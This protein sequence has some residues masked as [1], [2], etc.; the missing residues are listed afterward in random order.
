MLSRIWG[1]LALFAFLAPILPAT[2]MAMA[3]SETL[4]RRSEQEAHKLIRANDAVGALGADLFGEEFNLYSGALSFAAVDVS[5][6]GN[7]ELPMQIGR[8]FSVESIG[9]IRTTQF[10][11]GS[12]GDWEMD[13]PMIHGTFARDHGFAATTGL[14]TAR[15]SS[16]S[17]PPTAKSN[18]RTGANFDATEYWH[19]T[20]LYMPG[21][22]DQE[23]LR[24]APGNGQA[25][26]GNISAYPL[27]TRD[28]WQI[29]CLSTLHPNNFRPGTTQREEGEGFTVLS[30]SGVRYRFD[31]MT[32]RTAESVSK[33][34]G[35][36]LR[37]G[38]VVLQDDDYTLFRKE[39]RLYPTLIEDRFGN[40]VTLSW[41][42]DQLRSMVASD[43]RSI[44]M[45]YIQGTNRVETV[46]DGSRTWR[47]SYST[48]NHL[49]TVTLPDNTSTWTY[50]LANLYHANIQYN[51]EGNCGPIPMLA[52]SH[53][54][55]ITHPS[56]A[57]GSFTVAPVRHGRTWVDYEC[58]QI[59]PGNY[60][61]KQPATFD[62]LSLTRK[63]ISGLGLSTIEWQYA[64]GTALPCYD[65][66]T[67]P[68]G[69]CTA[70]SPTT[71]TVQVTRTM[72]GFPA[73]VSSFKFG[74]RVRSDE[75]KMLQREIGI[76]TTW[77]RV[78]TTT[79]ESPIDK[80]FPNPIGES[81]NDRGD[82]YFSTRIIPE[83][84][85]KGTVNGRNYNW[86]ATNWDQ[87]GNPIAVAKSSGS[88]TKTETIS[89]VHDSTNWVL[90]QLDRVVDNSTGVTEVD[91][92]Y[93]AA[94]ALPTSRKVFNRPDQTMLYCNAISSSCA[95][96]GLLLS[97][98]DGA[99]KKTTFSNH[100]RGI[101]QRVTFADNRSISGVV[102]NEG[103]VT[104]YIDEMGYTTGYQYD[105]LGR[106]T[107]IV[108]PS[109]DIPGWTS[110][111]ISF[112][113]AGVAQF[114]IAAEQWK[115]SI[116]TGRHHK[117]VFFDALWRPVLTREWDTGGGSARFTVRRFDAE[118]REVFTSYPVST[119][120]TIGDV[121]AGVTKKFDGLGRL[122][123]SAASSELGPLETTISYTGSYH[124]EIT[125]PRGLVT[126]IEFLQYDDADEELPLN[127]L[128]PEGVTI[129]MTRDVWGKPTAITRSG[130]GVT[131]TRNF[132]YDAHQRLCKT[133]EPERGAEVFH[134]DS[135]NNID[136]SAKGQT[137]TSVS[138]CQDSSVSPASQ[139]RRT[140]DARDRLTK[141]DY[142][143][144]TLDEFR[145]YEA[146]G[147]L[148]TVRRGSSGTNDILFTY[149]YNRRRLLTSETVDIDTGLGGGASTTDW[150]YNGLGHVQDMRYLNG[151]RLSF[152]PNA[153]GQPT[154]VLGTSPAYTYA[155][156]VKYFPNG[157]MAEFTYGNN[158]VH[159]LTQNSRDLP[160]RSLDKK[161]TMI[162]VDNTYSYDKNGNPSVIDDGLVPADD[163]KLVYDGLDR[164]I[165]VRDFADS[166]K[167]IMTYDAL[168]NLT[169]YNVPGR[170]FYYVYDHSKQRLDRTTNGGG[171]TQVT[172]GYDPRGNV[173]S[174]AQGGS[175]LR[176]TYD[177]ADRVT[178]NSRDTV[179]LA[180]FRYDG[181][182]RR[183]KTT[184]ANGDQRF[185]IYSQGGQ[186]LWEGD[187][188]SSEGVQT[189]INYI[190]LNGSL[191]AKLIGEA[192]IEATRAGENGEGVEVPPI[193]DPFVNLYEFD[194]AREVVAGSEEDL[195][196][197]GGGD[198]AN[199]T[200]AT[201][202]RV[203]YVHTDAL[204]SPVAET[205]STGAILAGSRTLY[206]PY[207]KPLTT[208]REGAPSYTGHQYDTSTGLLYMQA[209]LYDPALGK[210]FSTDPMAVD[211]SS[212]FNWNRFAYANNSPY[213]FTDPDG[214]DNVL[215]V[216]ARLPNGQAQS[217]DRPVLA[218]QVAQRAVDLTIN[219]AVA[220]GDPEL[221]HNARMWQ[222]TVDP[223]ASKAPQQGGLAETQTGTF[224]ASG[225]VA[226]VQTVFSNQILRAYGPTSDGTVR[227]SGLSSKAGDATLLG[228]GGHEL[229]H[230]T[231]ENRSMPSGKAKEINASQTAV[232]LSK[233]STDVSKDSLKI[234]ETCFP[235][236]GQ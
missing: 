65:P 209:R 82:S 150:Y 91:I 167:A 58:L 70:S 11:A 128:A 111:N 162:V 122:V 188:R 187:F 158:V 76:G 214:R 32:Y 228:L 195:A 27:V 79:Y 44:T 33:L 47:Y 85:R 193:N 30:P 224:R 98:A 25:P 71:K 31:W 185:Q 113:K 37:E 57:T 86:T 21:A 196:G 208:P 64:Y 205:S 129:E 212:A 28:S 191:I 48:D 179:A 104:S 10:L 61:Q 35:A 119:L 201:T 46:R 3:T 26:G 75:G 170:D 211:T 59:G 19:G 29:G 163:K 12:F 101:P 141:V 116:S 199:A 115:Q 139:I 118:G 6:P 103:W 153:W 89:Y 176:F 172:L 99:G 136:W 14:P 81:I 140:Y 74:T 155:T 84:N 123:S 219:A 206:E 63:Q 77:K 54:G 97:I 147:A 109:G 210:F 184:K 9:P 60:L 5:L 8:K 194:N 189:H 190:Q 144:A 213:K 20:S 230:S 4:P 88:R 180:S 177:L 130:N 42:G 216:L 67:V 52:S 49:R 207:G 137:L 18:T 236:G 41:V 43:G 15:C 142:P 93:D 106:L 120:N 2:A 90:S 227:S 107:S 197:S 83:R 173:L 16:F 100:K 40:T 174:R 231:A 229:G 148:A 198:S 94:T 53:T 202:F 138:A 131:A 108:H 220:S 161:G 95:A 39:A 117:E 221:I 235:G 22:G 45:T 232:N 17:Q 87:Y 73:E 7:D 124:K 62:N 222:V 183:T 68:S 203:Q 160:L 159:T 105:S 151:P 36:P 218:Q 152:A 114:G 204:G 178:A 225:K 233:T 135:A 164:L 69:G 226:F 134:Y 127:I 149:T 125:N 1:R 192:P 143:D 166:P 13:L 92:D 78:D 80:A 38:E 234:C 182:G 110:T 96:K 24:R 217:P 171:F 56:G 72:A 50:N 215:G 146:D 223:S 145:S 51:G 112:A 186:F 102:S 175:T 121:T 181:L 23:I 126:K 169:R 157:A 156:N 66:A 154:Q 132:V 133:M 55:T 34:Y 165:S 200:T 168:D